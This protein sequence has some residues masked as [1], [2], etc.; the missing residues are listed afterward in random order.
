MYLS[1]SVFEELLGGI[2]MMSGQPVIILKE[3]T[4]RETG[5]SAL[6]N[7]IAAAL[8]IADAVRSTLGPYGMDKMLVDSLGDVTVTNDGATILKELEIEHPAAKM[9][10]EVAK[11]QDSEVGDGT[12]TAVVLAGELLR[13]AQE[14]VDKNI[15][16]T[17]V[18]TGYMG[19]KEAA[20]KILE[21]IAIETKGDSK[22]LQYVGLTSLSGKNVGGQNEFLAD[23][24][25]KAV[26]EVAE[27]RDGRQYV[28][29][30]RI[31]VEKKHGASILSSELVQGVVID[32]ERVHP[33]M[34]ELVDNAK[35]ALITQ[36]L[37]IKK[38]EISSSI[39]VRDPM[40]L[41]QFLDE[42]EKE[43]RDMA[44]KL[45]SAGANVVICEKGIS[46]VVAYYLSKNKVYAVQ[47]AKKS[48]M[49]ALSKATG[50][51]L[52]ANLRDFSER[53]LGSA[54]KVEER[55][56]AGDSMTFVT[57]CR[58]PKSVSVLL[59]GGTEH[60]VNDYER[61][62][63]DAVKSVA[64]AFEDGKVVAGGGSAEIE[65]AMR[66]RDQSTKVGGRE[67]LAIIAFADALEHIPRVLAENAG[68]DPVDSMIEL[69]SKHSG[70]REG[71]YFGVS[72]D[73]GKIKDMT[74]A[75]VFEPL[76]VKRQAIASATEVACMILRID[77]VVAAKKPE[78]KGGGSGGAGGMPGGM[79]PGMPTGM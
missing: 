61:A 14:L 71:A 73:D 39:E 40:K 3:G 8:A 31:K 26:R 67:Q 70:N 2:T 43:Q 52:V 47:R 68:K 69:K 75:K 79:P 51:R 58:N 22:Y 21:G 5:R 60:S 25:V 35:I 42:E 17:I 76:R 23:L 13:E 33:R 1:L 38:T 49:E 48:D 29:V 72:A 66:L 4:Q 7:N 62:F 34:P 54:K 45:I 78:E 37:E 44:E 46:D 53:D 20:E 56:V 32:K 30:K 63:N 74:K 19:A 36:A 10:V 57:G 12:T 24:A 50:G 11:T 9:I 41:Q 27:E 18:S 6:H 77:D 15:H 28:D 16:P 59:R 64:A 65:V 55:K